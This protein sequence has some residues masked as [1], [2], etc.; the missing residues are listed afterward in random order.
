MATDRVGIRKCCVAACEVQGTLTLRRHEKVA[1][2]WR[3]IRYVRMQDRNKVAGQ[4]LETSWIFELDE[5]ACV[6]DKTTQA[7]ISHNA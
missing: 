7:Q 2:G 6:L 4:A 1:R 3:T 5:R